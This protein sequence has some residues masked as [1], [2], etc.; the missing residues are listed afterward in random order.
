MQSALSALKRAIRRL[1]LAR[2]ERAGLRVGKDLRLNGMPYFGREPYLITLG[3]HVQIS[4][5]VTF[6][7][8][9]GATWTV[10]D[11]AAFADIHKFGRIVV[12]DNCFVGHGAIILPGVTIGANSIVAAGA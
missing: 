6:L 2:V 7:T 11:R 12:G 9:D 8:H 3:D 4:G 5:A 1:Q 10:S